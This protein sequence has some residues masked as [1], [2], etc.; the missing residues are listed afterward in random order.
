M[1][2]S[3]QV[4]LDVSMPLD[5]HEDR[6]KRH[7]RT[8]E[9]NVSKDGLEAGNRGHALVKFALGATGAGLVKTFFEGQITLENA[10]LAK[11]TWTHLFRI[12]LPSA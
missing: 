2:R 6:S 9:L 11:P 7:T 12:G 8:E 3:L 10:W 5:E 4:L 1:A